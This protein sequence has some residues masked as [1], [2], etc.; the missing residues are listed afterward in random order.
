M[1]DKNNPKNWNSLNPKREFKITITQNVFNC[2]S[3]TV[4][5]WFEYNKDKNKI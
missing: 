5:D 2:W 4:K 1:V 3:K